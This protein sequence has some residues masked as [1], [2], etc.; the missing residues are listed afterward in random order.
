MRYILIFGEMPALPDDLQRMKRLKEYPKR[1]TCGMPPTNQ[2]KCGT[3]N[4]PIKVVGLPIYSYVVVNF[5]A[6]L[7]K[8]NAMRILQPQTPTG[9][10]HVNFISRFTTVYSTRA[11]HIST[12][13]PFTS[14]NNWCKGERIKL[15]FNLSLLNGDIDTFSSW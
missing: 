9:L 14:A 8:L 3:N 15:K 11:S 7:G 5:W 1:P 13:K 10:N 12:K 6:M 2:E 4:F